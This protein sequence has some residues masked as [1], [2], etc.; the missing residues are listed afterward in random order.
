MKII[1]HRINSIK[2]IKSL[3]ADGFDVEVDFWY[4]KG[5]FFIGHDA[6]EKK[7][8]ISLLN[9]NVVWSHAKNLAALERL[10]RN[11]FNCFFHDSDQCVLTS[12]RLIWTYPGKPVGKRSIALFPKKITKKLLQCYGLCVDEPVKWRSLLCQKNPT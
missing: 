9:R 1:A 3:V 4:V 7:I 5:A 12:R 11:G 10:L 2:A 6:P 8:D